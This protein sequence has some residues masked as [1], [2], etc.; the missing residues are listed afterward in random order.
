[1]KRREYKYEWDVLY[2]KCSKCWEFKTIDEYHKSKIWAFWTVW[3]CKLCMSSWQR[4]HYDLN[5]D[6]KAKQQQDYYWKNKE[7]I[8]NHK[9]QYRI[10]N[11]STYNQKREKINELIWFNRHT[12]HLRTI[13]YIKKNWLRPTKCSICW[14]EWVIYSHHPSYAKF[15]DWSKVVFCCKSCHAQIHSWRIA[16]PKPINLLKPFN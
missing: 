7:R 14:D 16:C 8:N 15:D 3:M 13:N 4:K 11:I 12:F 10:D 2:V 1:M 5:R 6:Y 9:R